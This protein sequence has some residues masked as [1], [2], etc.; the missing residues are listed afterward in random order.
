MYLHNGDFQSK[1]IFNKNECIYDEI[2]LHGLQEG[3]YLKSEIPYFFSASDGHLSISTQIRT[4][5]HYDSN[6]TLLKT[7]HLTY[8]TEC[9]TLENSQVEKG[10][11]N[12]HTMKSVFP[13]S[14]FLLSLLIIMYLRRQKNAKNHIHR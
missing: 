7:I 4:L 2:Y 1:T 8:I 3:D 10:T 9:Q 6:Q 13:L 14:L 12:I 11:E 5:G